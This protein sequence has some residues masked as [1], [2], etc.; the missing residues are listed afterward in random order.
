MIPLGAVEEL[1]K[2]T[3]RFSTFGYTNHLKEYKDKRSKFL[4][5]SLR[6][7][8]PEKIAKENPER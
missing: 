5:N 7:L 4:V 3:R 8:N 6:K 1:K 2:I